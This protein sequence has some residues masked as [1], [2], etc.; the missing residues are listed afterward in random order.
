MA[1]SNTTDVPVV[2]SDQD[3]EPRDKRSWT[4]DEQWAWLSPRRPAFRASQ[5]AGERASFLA[6]LYVDWFRAW[7]EIRA[8]YGH[9]DK[10]R[11][12]KE[13]DEALGLAIAK[14]REQ[15]ESWFKNK[16]RARG[17]TK[18]LAMLLASAGIT[19]K[20]KRL[21]QAREVFSK[22]NYKGVVQPIVSEKLTQI[23]HDTGRRANRK[24]TMK[25]VQSTI[26]EEY[27]AAS[28]EVKDAIAGHIAQEKQKALAAREA[29]ALERD[30]PRTPQDY[31]AALDIAPKLVEAVLDPLSRNTGW[32]YSLFGA[33]PVPEDSGSM[34]SMAAHFG[35]NEHGHTLAQATPN[36]Q[37]QFILPF[38]RFAQA[39]FPRDV[40]EQRSIPAQASQ[41]G[42]LPAENSPPPHTSAPSEPAATPPPKRKRAPKSKKKRA[43]RKKTQTAVVATAASGS[44]ST[45]AAGPAP[46]PSTSASPAPGGYT[47]ADL[48]TDPTLY[49]FTDS[50]PPPARFGHASSAA[51]GPEFTMD[52][53]FAATEDEFGLDLTLFQPDIPDLDNP[54]IPLIFPSAYALAALP[55]PA[56]AALTPISEPPPQ[57]AL[58]VTLSAADCMRVPAPESMPEPPPTPVPQPEPAPRSEP[59]PEPAPTPIPEPAPTPMQAS[60]PPRESVPE[61]TP[62]E[63]SEPAPVPAPAPW[64]VPESTIAPASGPVPA[65]ARASTPTGKSQNATSGDSAP[66]PNSPLP[67]RLSR[68]RNNTTPGHP[69]VQAIT[70]A[71]TEAA[72]AAPVQTQDAP[73]ART[74]RTGRSVRSTRPADADWNGGPKHGASTSKKGKG[75]PPNKKQ[76]K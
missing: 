52:S 63:D 4:T 57:S 11:L 2:A 40:R 26:A 68:L 33:G 7:P 58:A 3:I 47:Q 74:T 29:L 36:F 62:L 71:A 60:A 59:A 72:P 43:S 10:S 12:T 45:S 19:K 44:S 55:Y 8:L 25:I 32:T 15:L 27:E 5:R 69:A 50:T 76:K 37:E 14:R 6:G 64:A 1:S 51:M 56:P 18:T 39:V 21:P 38:G 28:Q 22:Q 66:L 73:A 75:G 41:V 31:Q 65:P 20:S 46:A 53:A 34:S 30:K 9:D 61:S 42:D 48:L 70:A 13:E 54:T 23:E 67:P 49:S 24:E 35:R 17:T 16:E